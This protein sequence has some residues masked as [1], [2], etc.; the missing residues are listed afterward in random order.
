MAHME[1]LEITDFKSFKGKHVIGP[2]KKF[3]AI[4]GPNGSGKEGIFALMR[5]C[6]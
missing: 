6:F 5:R 2:M 3:T 4:V 1:S